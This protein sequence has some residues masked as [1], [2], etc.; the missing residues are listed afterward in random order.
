[1]PDVLLFGATGYTG[2][3]TTRAL[4]K[5]GADFIIAGRNRAKLEALAAARGAAGVA[6]ATVGDV[7]GLAEAAR[8][9]RVLLT[10]VGPF[11]ILGATAVDAALRAGVHYV[12]CCGESVFIGDLIA[13]Y[14]SSARAARIALAPALGFDEVPADVA[15]TIATEG[16]DEPDLVLTYALPQHASWGTIRSVMG[17]VSSPGQWIDK[18]GPRTIRP[19]DEQ[20]WAPMPPPLGPLRAVSF[21]L[22]EGHLAPLHLG[23]RSLKLFVA[24]GTLKR[25]GLSLAR[26]ALRLAGAV[27]VTAALDRALTVPSRGPGLGR[28]HDGRWTILAEATSG[29]RKRNVAISGSDVY[30]LTA[31]LLAAGALKMAK[32]HPSP[33]GVVAPVQA[34]GLAM[35]LDELARHGVRI[36]VFDS[37][38]AKGD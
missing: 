19:G 28:R 22:A 27:P 5:R 16:L 15:A 25:L 24:A 14:D 17:I 35:W 4:S 1:M 13:R 20:R 11:G 26:H 33:T 9:A 18:G 7:S 34:G 8:D 6:V 37:Q 10:C 38:L 31:E 36:E 12:D 3:L 30:G 32:D 2:Q 29:R 23:V 21:P